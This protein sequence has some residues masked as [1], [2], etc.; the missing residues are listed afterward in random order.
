MLKLVLALSILA[1]ILISCAPL[2][3]NPNIK[4]SPE[5]IQSSQL[6]V[7]IGYAQAL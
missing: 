1:P 3:K 6:K 4:K 5:R 7:M 2:T